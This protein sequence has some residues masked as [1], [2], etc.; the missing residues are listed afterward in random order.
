MDKRFCF[1]VDDNIRVFKE[2]TEVG[3][4]SVFDHPYLAAYRRLHEK[5]GLCVQLNLFLRVR[6]LYPCFDD[7]PIPRRI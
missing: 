4:A 3:G 6:G 5:H 1:T 7:R 2:L